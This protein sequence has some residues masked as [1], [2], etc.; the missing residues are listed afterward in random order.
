MGISSTSQGVK[1]VKTL[2]IDASPQVK[3]DSDDP[4]KLW[5]EF[6]NRYNYSTWNWEVERLA[7]SKS[8]MEQDGLVGNTFIEKFIDWLDK[9]GIKAEAVW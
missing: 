7:R 9:R 4:I 2:Y 6:E 3:V 1:Q 5:Q 8:L